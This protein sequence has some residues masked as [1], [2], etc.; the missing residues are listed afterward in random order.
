MILLLLT[1]RMAFVFRSSGRRPIGEVQQNCAVKRWPQLSGHSCIVS[2][3]RSDRL[4]GV[5]PSL[6][7]FYNLGLREVPYLPP[8]RYIPFTPPGSRRPAAT[9]ST[10][11]EG[12]ARKTKPGKPQPQ[13]W[14]LVAFRPIKTFNRLSWISMPTLE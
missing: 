6:A 13:P 12:F 1:F 5:L 3:A 8:P 10:D 9:S 2:D 7:V 4:H 14:T 11:A